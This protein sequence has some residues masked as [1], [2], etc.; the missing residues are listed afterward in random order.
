MA[1][2]CT[3]RSLRAIVNLRQFPYCKIHITRIEGSDRERSVIHIYIESPI[4]QSVSIFHRIAPMR[5]LF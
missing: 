3:T 5:L 4:C 1:L 2:S